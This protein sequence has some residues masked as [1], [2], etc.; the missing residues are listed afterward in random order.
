[1]QIQQRR[2]SIYTREKM[3]AKRYSFLLF[4]KILEKIILK[5][6]NT[7]MQ[8]S[9]QFRTDKV[10]GTGVTL[11]RLNRILI[12]ALN[13]DNIQTDNSKGHGFTIL[14]NFIPIHKR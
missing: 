3:Y 6:M 8:Q 2:Y 4:A 12:E 7:A 1:M 14:N 9:K 10:S 5:I 11:K 13:K